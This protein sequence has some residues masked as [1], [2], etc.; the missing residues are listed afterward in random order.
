VGRGERA[1]S[2]VSS[3]SATGSCYRSCSSSSEIDPLTDDE[4]DQTLTGRR[5]RVDAVAA[6]I[7]R[8]AVDDSWW[9]SSGRFLASSSHIARAAEGV[10]TNEIARPAW[11]ARATPCGRTCAG[12]AVARVVARCRR[13]GE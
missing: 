12:G 13:S 7:S 8:P 6:R 3:A 4:R 5:G 2:A 11:S 1:H 9:R 10:A